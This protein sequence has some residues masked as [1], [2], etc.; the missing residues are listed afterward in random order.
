M[1]STVVRPISGVL[2]V[3]EGASVR[4]EDASSTQGTADVIPRL[5]VPIVL[6]SWGPGR[7]VPV[8]VTTFSVEEQQYS[9]AL[10][11]VRAKVT[12]GLTV[13]NEDHLVNIAGESSRT[14]SSSWP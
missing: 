12:M 7:I 9:V 10:F 3:P 14:K 4:R 1:L 11:P 5:E 8:R 2:N 13:L 6:F